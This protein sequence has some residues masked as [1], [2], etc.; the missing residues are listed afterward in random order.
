M[1]LVPQLSRAV[2]RR[3]RGAQALTDGLSLPVELFGDW[4]PV[5]GQEPDL[6]YVD[7][8]YLERGRFVNVAPLPIGGEG[9]I[10]TDAVLGP[11]PAFFNRLRPSLTDAPGVQSIG[12][13]QLLDLRGEGSLAYVTAGAHTPWVA[14]SRAVQ[15]EHD[16][17]FGTGES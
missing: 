6:D 10:N 7:T 12:V 3:L 15:L 14:C 13:Q 9:D 11:D 17:E 4:E 8:D 16:Y 1:L 5:P 2:L